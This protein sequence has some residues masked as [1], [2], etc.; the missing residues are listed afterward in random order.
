VASLG[1]ASRIRPIRPN[2]IDSLSSPWRVQVASGVGSGS[3]FFSLPTVLRVWWSARMN[4]ILHQSCSSGAVLLAA[5]YSA[6]SCAALT[7]MRDLCVFICA[8]KR[9]EPVL[10][11]AARVWGKS[12]QLLGATLQRGKHAGNSFGRMLV[13]WVLGFP[14]A[15]TPLRTRGTIGIPSAPAACVGC[16]SEQ[17]ISTP[18]V[19]LCHIVK[20]RYIRSVHS[21]FV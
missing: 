2:S 15:Y 16:G 20:S 18:Q 3:S 6:L 8:H 10:E 5:L 9:Y 11:C 13:R 7:Q 19:T 12:R 21:C 1:A 14:W 4:P 17:T